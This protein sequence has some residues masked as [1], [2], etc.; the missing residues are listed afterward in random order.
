MTASLLYLS[1]ADVR[2][3]GVSPD[4]LRAAVAAVF[5]AKARG[6][7]KAE[8]K[9][10]V[11]IAPGHF[12]QAMPG[13][14]LSSGVA[15]MKWVGVV[16]AG[17]TTGPTIS[18]LIVLADLA[19]GAPVA[20]MD[21]T[22]ITGARTA[23]MTALAAGKLAR[24]DSATIGFVG[25][26]IQA[27]SHLEALRRVLPRLADVVAYS[28]SEASAERFAAE[29]REGGLAAET[30]RNPREAVEGLD[31]V[32][33]T[34]P[35]APGLAAFLDPAWLAPGAFASAVDLGRS[36]VAD[37][38][39]SLDLLATDEHE[40]SRILGAAGK[41]AWGGPY[42]ADLAGLVTGREPGRTDPGQRAMF[43]FA[44]HSLADLAAAEAVLDAARRRGIGTALPL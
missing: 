14:L 6:E 13:A 28:R 27:R 43:L 18:A 29:A 37:R 2:A 38:L 36:W 7:A 30:T 9:L 1:A 33:T 44:G 12:F 19:T 24:A 35:A 41:L 31:V 32:V 17:Q 40:Q 42:H 23:A 26:G 25:C 3:A 5:A 39:R 8:P 20:V 16:P 21:G 10:S 15:G 34:V 22:W 11:A 4:A